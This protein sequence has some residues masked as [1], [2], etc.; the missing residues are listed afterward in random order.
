MSTKEAWGTGPPCR[1]DPCL[2]LAALFPTALGGDGAA[3]LVRPR[4]SQ[5]QHQPPPRSDRPPGLATS[6]F[7]VIAMPKA[8]SMLFREQRRPPGW[9]FVFLE[10]EET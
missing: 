10:L 9:E 3:G 5:I 1:L 8:V 6:L 4:K 7:P 2:G